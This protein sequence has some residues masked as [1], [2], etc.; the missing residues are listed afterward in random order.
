L[1]KIR[2]FNYGVGEEGDE[3]VAHPTEVWYRESFDQ[4]Q[5]WKK[6]I[7]ARSQS[8]SDPLPLSDASFNLY[9]RPLPIDRLKAKDLFDMSHKFLTAQ[10]H[11][12]YPAPVEAPVE[13]E[14][15]EEEL[16]S[17]SSSTASSSSEEEEKAFDITDVED[18]STTP[19]LWGKC[20]RSTK[21]RA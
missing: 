3:L 9:E 7:V 8:T 12:L 21:N 13:V 17:S 4:S 20:W 19:S 5:P 14:E 10:Y 15:E 6:I 2:W 18:G 1:D 11:P 16:S